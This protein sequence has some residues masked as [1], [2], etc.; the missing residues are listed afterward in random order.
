MWP[1]PFPWC[2]IRW[3]CWLGFLRPQIHEACLPV[4]GEARTLEGIDFLRVFVIEFYPH[5]AKWLCED[6]AFQDLNPAKIKELATAH[7]LGQTR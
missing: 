3:R 2:T 6:G 4:L 7:L 5:L 1:L